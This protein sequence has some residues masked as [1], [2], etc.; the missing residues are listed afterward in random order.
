VARF[1]MMQFH[2]IDAMIE[3]GFAAGMEALQT[4]RARN[5]S[6]PQY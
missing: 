6:A 3:R 5:V 2:A 1:G 4:W